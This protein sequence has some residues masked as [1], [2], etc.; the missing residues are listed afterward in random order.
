MIYK[1]Y[2]IEQNVVNNLVLKESKAEKYVKNK[3]I[4]KIIFV[5]NR[6]I[7]YITTN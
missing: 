4:K 7:N 2:L 3:N 6:I 5:K 1:S